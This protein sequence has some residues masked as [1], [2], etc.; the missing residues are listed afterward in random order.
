MRHSCEMIVVD[1]LPIIRKE[2]ALELIEAHNIK[3]AAVAR[4]F[5][6]SGTAISQYVHGSRG[7]RALLEDS[8]NY[9]EFLKEIKFS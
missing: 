6:V 3:K 8:P 1:V 4:M 7:N 5:S 9:M 2:L